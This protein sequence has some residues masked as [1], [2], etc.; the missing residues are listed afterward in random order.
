MSLEQPARAGFFVGMNLQH[1]LR[2]AEA[3]LSATQMLCKAKRAT[4][5]DVAKA[6]RHLADVRALIARPARPVPT[7][8][9]EPVPVAVA[10]RPVATDEGLVLQADLSKEADRL[11]RQMAEMS[12]QLHKVPPSQN[13]PELTA[14]ILALKAQIE[15]VWDKKRYLE[16]NGGLPEPDGAETAPTA[17][18]SPQ[19]YELAYRKSRLI[20]LRCKLTRKLDDPKAKPAKRQEWE[21]DLMKAE[22][23]IQEL[24]VQLATL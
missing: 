3:A 19:R 14:P 7:D 16:R 18:V 13:C 17:N 15:A 12:N 20:D 2:Q 6:E 22:M 24:E 8:V 1:Q 11:N 10:V 4:T 9:P 5:N 23:E 21:T